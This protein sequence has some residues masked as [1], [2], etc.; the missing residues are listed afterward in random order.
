MRASP[1]RM[2]MRVSRRNEVDTVSNERNAVWVIAGGWVISPGLP[3]TSPRM[4]PSGSQ[5]RTLPSMGACWQVE[6]LITRFRSQ[7]RRLPAPP[8]IARR[9]AQLRHTAPIPQPTHGKSAFQVRPGGVAE[10]LPAPACAPA[11]CRSQANAR[12]PMRIHSAAQV[13]PAAGTSV[14]CLPAAAR[15]FA[16]KFPGSFFQERTKN[17]S[18]QSLTLSRR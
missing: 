7:A 17:P 5:A 2:C 9:Y 3:S 15:F 1:V 14:H 11:S 6:R 16:Q 8:G 4:K 13:R 18:A 10:I 12:P